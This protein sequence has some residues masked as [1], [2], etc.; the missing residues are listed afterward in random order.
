MSMQSALKYI[1]TIVVAAFLFTTQTHAC[2]CM[3]Q[4]KDEQFQNADA[5]FS[6]WLLSSHD[7]RHEFEWRRRVETRFLVVRTYKGSLPNEIGVRHNKS[8]SM[9]GLSYSGTTR[10][11]VFAS[12]TENGQLVT[13]L[14]Q[15]RDFNGHPESEVRGELETLQRKYKAPTTLPEITF[16]H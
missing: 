7:V 14:C 1:V 15:A 2:T 6:G 12:Q 4:S 9:C 3:Q 5:V 11:V 13:S 10:L 16:E 8:E